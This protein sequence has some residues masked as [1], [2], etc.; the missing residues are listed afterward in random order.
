M[1]TTR[2]SF[3][4]CP[5]FYMCD[6]PYFTDAA[7]LKPDV[8]AGPKKLIAESGYKGEKIVVLDAIETALSPQMLVVSQLMRDAGLN[9]WS[10][11]PGDGLGHVVEL[12]HQ[13]RT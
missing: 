8:S 4:V 10:T 13:Q 2:R 12:A 7:W 6:L 5:S 3:T 1:S 11:I 9:F